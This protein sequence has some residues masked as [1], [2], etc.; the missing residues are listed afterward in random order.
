ML[1]YL[2]YYF[3]AA[4]QLKPCHLHVLPSIRHQTHRPRVQHSKSVSRL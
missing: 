3:S 1:I 4:D 2:I